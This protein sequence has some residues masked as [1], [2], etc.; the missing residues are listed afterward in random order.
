EAPGVGLQVLWKPAEYITILGNQYFGTD[1]LGT[2][3]RKRIHTDDSIMARL[4]NNPGG[5][6][7]KLAMSLTLDAGCEFGPG[8][9]DKNGKPI[10][11]TG[12]GSGP[13]SCGGGTKA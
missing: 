10:S 2:P 8:S 5:G 1:A 7:S 3:G 9:L 11:V 12:F 6:F 4:Y 13:V